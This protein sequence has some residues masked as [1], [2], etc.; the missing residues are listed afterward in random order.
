M[1]RYVSD[2]TTRE[3]IINQLEKA[4][5]GA[6]VP[7]PVTAEY[8]EFV[9][10]VDSAIHAV[11]Q[12]ISRYTD[13]VFVPYK[14]TRQYFF[15][16]IADNG[17]WLYLDGGP[18]LVLGEDLLVLS[19]VTWNDELLS[20]SYYREYPAN[21]QPYSHIKFS[22]AGLPSWGSEFN[23]TIDVNGTW[24]YHDNTSQMYTQID[25]NVTINAIATSLTVTSAALYRTYQYIKIED[26]LLQITA[27]NETTHVLTVKRGV[28][29]T[30][31]AA[32]TTQAVSVFNPVEDIRLTATRLAAWAYNNR[33]DLGTALTLTD[34]S[35]IKNE[36]PA[37][38]YETLDKLQRQVFKAV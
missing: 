32:H 1:P 25:A 28:N 21:E 18:T 14:D 38:V 17:D 27:R 10:Y 26:E 29:G 12:F 16:E 31:A 19:A 11:S 37:F 34:G 3:D 15:N 4:D 23:D 24:G 22:G 13:C 6:S 30:T 8:A 7:A 9:A 2:Y 20:A 35:S 5:P 36:L 33:N